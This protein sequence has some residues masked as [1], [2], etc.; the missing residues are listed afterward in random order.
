MKRSTP[1]YSG[2]RPTYDQSKRRSS[3]LEKKRG[4]SPWA[5]FLNRIFSEKSLAKQGGQE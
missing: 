4:V 5:S 2:T 3:P 1:R